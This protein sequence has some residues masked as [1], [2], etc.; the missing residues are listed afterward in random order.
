MALI[1]IGDL[2]FS[3]DKDWKIAVGRKMIEWMIDF[4]ENIPENTLILSG[5]ITDK[6]INTGTVYRMVEEFISVCKFKSIYILKGNH[7]IHYKNGIQSY[8]GDFLRGYTAIEILEEPG[9]ILNI[10]GFN[11]LSLPHYDFLE[12]FPNM[13]TF[14]NSLRVKEDIDIIVGHLSDETLPL[15]SDIDLSN[16][17]AKY[18]SLGHIHSPMNENYMGSLYPTSVAEHTGNRYYH[19]YE[20]RERSLGDIPELLHYE[21]IIYPREPVMKEGLIQVF[22]ILNY[23]TN[24]DGLSIYDKL[25][26]KQKISSKAL[27]VFDSE[28]ESKALKEI[29]NPSEIIETCLEEHKYSENVKK[30]VRSYLL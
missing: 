19:K 22:T 18:R 16:L 3:D 15:F 7:D 21:Q 2:H 24:I 25:Y 29:S 17:K 13:T 26:I 23:P 8:T 10:E 6:S 5:D 27:D 20:G 1:V 11:V 9:Q 28:L 14:Y 4:K 30:L 12:G